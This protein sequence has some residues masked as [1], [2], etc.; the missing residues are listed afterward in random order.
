MAETLTASRC[1]RC[2]RLV[3]PPASLCPE[4]PVRMEAAGVAP[5]GEVVSF[6]SGVAKLRL[7]D[8][9]SSHYFSGVT[10]LRPIPDD[11]TAVEVTVQDVADCGG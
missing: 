7:S 8:L 10:L 9:E 5:L 6:T 3:G 1:P 4:H 2:R 11:D